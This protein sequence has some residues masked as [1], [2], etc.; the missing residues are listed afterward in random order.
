MRIMG[1]GFERKKPDNN[2]KKWM[3]TQKD[4]NAMDVDAMSIEERNELMKKGAC[5]RCK[6]PGHLSK[7]CPTKNKT[8]GTPQEAQKKMTPREM[9]KYIQSLTA[10]LNN[11]E[12]AE[13]FKKAKEEG[14]K[15]GEPDQRWSLLLLIFTL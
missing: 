3:F 1:R 9:Y 11:E 5:F 15:E 6:K 12:K 8:T 7:D 13:F 2:G 10:Q 4:P 14:F